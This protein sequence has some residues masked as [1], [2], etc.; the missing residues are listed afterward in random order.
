MDAFAVGPAIVG[1]LLIG[2]SATLLLLANG[3]IAGVSGVVDAALSP[4]GGSG[5]RFAFLGGLLASGPVLAAGGARVPNVVIDAPITLVLLAGVLVGFGSRL[6]SGCTSGHG[7]CGLSR[8][9]RRSLFATCVFM[10]T[11]IATVFVARHLVGV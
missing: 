2:A 1:G 5:W 11:A 8:G 4:K 6:G 7:V 3:R 10:A 9:S